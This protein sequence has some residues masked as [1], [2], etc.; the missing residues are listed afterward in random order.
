[1]QEEDEASTVTDQESDWIEDERFSEESK[2]DDGEWYVSE[3]IHGIYMSQPGWVSGNYGPCDSMLCDPGHPFMADAI[4]L[5]YQAM[6]PHNSEET[7]MQ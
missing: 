7:A 6:L 4:C 2:S 3:W 5:C 1:M